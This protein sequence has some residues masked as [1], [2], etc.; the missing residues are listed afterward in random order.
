MPST[1]KQA[2]WKGRLYCCIQL[3]CSPLTVPLKIV[4]KAG[5]IAV[6]AVLLMDMLIKRGEDF[7]KKKPALKDWKDEREMALALTDCLLALALCP[8]TIGAS[9]IRYFVGIIN[10]TRAFPKRYY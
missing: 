2:N 8:L 9:R 5:E 3:A 7:L 10:P 4:K 1:Y 6:T